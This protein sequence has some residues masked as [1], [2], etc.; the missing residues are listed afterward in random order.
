MPLPQP[1][2]SGFC[3]KDSEHI[4]GASNTHAESAHTALPTPTPTSTPNAERDVSDSEENDWDP[5]EIPNTPY[6][7]GFVIN[8]VRHEPPEPFGFHYDIEHSPEQPEWKNLSQID[9]CLSRP[10]PAGRTDPTVSKCLTITSTIRTGRQQGAQIVVV[11]R[12][13]VA[14][15][16]DPLYYFA[17]DEWGYKD[18][19]VR[20]SDRDYCSEAA[21]FEQLQSSTQ[22]LAVTP[23]YYGAWTMEVETPV[24]RARHKLVKRVRPVRLVLMERIYGDC[25]SNVDADD[26]REEI[27][28]AILKKVIIAET[29]IWDAGVDHQ[30]VCP[31]NVMILG[32]DNDDPDVPTSAINV[33]VKIIDFNVAEVLNNLLN[34]PRRHLPPL[35]L[36]KK[37]WPLKLLSPIVTRYGQMMEFSTQG[38]CSNEDKEPEKWL[39]QYFHNDDRYIPVV[40]DPSNPHKIPVYQEPSTAQRDT[41]SSSNSG[42]SVSSNFD[43]RSDSC[44]GSSAKGAKAGQD[45][46][47]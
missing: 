3:L 4:K 16:Y 27:R 28:S 38:W 36:R 31:R 9:Y 30:D 37:E 2:Q 13:M 45:Q 34:N 39:W 47:I 35:D 21:V 42:V 23:A 29:I 5:T 18:D 43:E 7:K 12:T 46:P 11:D 6:R 32:D 44:H 26:L 25:M 40:W 15:I 1:H 19:I 14:K 10:P 22:A 8:A 17:L 33:E 41:E 24:K 20:D